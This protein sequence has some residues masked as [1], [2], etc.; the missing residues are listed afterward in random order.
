MCVFFFKLDNLQENLSEI[1][2]LLKNCVIPGGNSFVQI[3][4]NPEPFL[5]DNCIVL[6]EQLSKSHKWQQAGI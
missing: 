3:K 1:F 5:S 2:V 4:A 6:K